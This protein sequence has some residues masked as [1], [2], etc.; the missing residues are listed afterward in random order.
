MNA[1]R[2]EKGFKGA[3]ELTDGVADG[4]GGEAVLLGG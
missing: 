4:N 2:T 3:G 1:L